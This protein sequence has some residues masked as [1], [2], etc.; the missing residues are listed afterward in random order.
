MILLTFLGVRYVYLVVDKDKNDVLICCINV[1]NIV[2]ML[3]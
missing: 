1:K 2:K 3:L